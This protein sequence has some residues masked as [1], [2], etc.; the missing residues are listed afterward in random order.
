[1]IDRIQ[2]EAPEHLGTVQEDVKLAMNVR[3]RIL[4]H[5]FVAVGEENN[6]NFVCG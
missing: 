4:P 6:A 5:D 3:M 2:T 1:M